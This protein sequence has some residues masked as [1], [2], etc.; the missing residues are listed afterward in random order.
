[1]GA[2][3]PIERHALNSGIE[4]PRGYRVSFHYN[5]HVEEHH[6]GRSHPMKPWRLQLTKQLI[7]AYGLNYAMETYLTPPATKPE[8]VRFHKP[9]YVDFLEK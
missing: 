3:T 1:M 5:P 7:M 8:M 4:R 9:E 2:S 6:F